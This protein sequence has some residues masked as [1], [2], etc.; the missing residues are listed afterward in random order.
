MKIELPVVK[1]ED[2]DR[3]YQ[4]K[5][6]RIGT[7]QLCAGGEKDRDSCTGDS[8]SP[9]MMRVLADNRFSVVGIVSYGPDTCGK[10][11]WPGVY[12]RVSEYTNWILD[13]LSP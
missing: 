5:G 10:E 1:N 3:V 12:T 11:N 9:L 6:R 4:D 2:C 13:Q 8:G 7:G